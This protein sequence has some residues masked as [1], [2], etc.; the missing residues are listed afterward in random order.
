MLTTPQRIE[1]AITTAQSLHASLA[2]FALETLEPTQKTAYQ[3]MAHSVSHVYLRLQERLE[4]LQI[5]Q[6]SKIPKS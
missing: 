4:Q 1:T 5:L 2:A 6:A 3:E